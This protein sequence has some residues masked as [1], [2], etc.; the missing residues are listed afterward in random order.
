MLQYLIFW[1]GLVRGGKRVYNVQGMKQHDKGAGRARCKASM[2]Q[3]VLGHDRVE[4]VE[5]S[6]QDR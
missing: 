3:I 2:W 5:H 1:R 4:G 6:E